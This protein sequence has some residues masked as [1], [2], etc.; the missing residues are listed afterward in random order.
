MAKILITNPPW[1]ITT[2]QGR[3]RLGIRAGSRWPLTTTDHYKPT[4][5]TPYPGFMGYATGYLQSQGIEAIFYDAIA[6]RHDYD[7]FYKRVDELK[8]DIII[9][10]TSTPSF[11]I[12]TQVTKR[13]HE[14]Y[15][16]CLVG[17][18]ASSFAEELIEQ[19]FIDYIL[20]GEYE[21]SSLEMLRTRRKG[22]Y[23]PKRVESLDDIPYPYRD[24][25]I[26]HHY[27]ECSCIKD[28]AFPQLW[29]YGSRGCAFHCS[30]CLW[31]HT[32]YQNKLSS[33]SPDNII[34]EADDMVR[35]Y[36][37]K[38]ILFD[39]DCW[40]LGGKARIMEIAD[41]L[42]EVGIPW[43][44][45]GRLDTCDKDIFKYVVDRGCVGLRLG[46][47]SLSQTL[48]DKTGKKLEVV[49]T[50]DMIEYIKT[51]DVSL[52]LLFMHHLPGETWWDRLKQDVR[53]R[54]L[55][56]GNPYIR[57]QNPPCV[58]FPGTPYYDEFVKAG[59]DP[60]K[61]TDWSEYDGANIG[62]NVIRLIKKY[63]QR[64]LK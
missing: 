54:R 22:V 46:V 9:Q 14:K 25:T 32:M 64:P 27:R 7:T 13:L 12:D 37:C 23:E 42:N 20:K 33:R 1:I 10:E 60:T 59:L 4:T 2:P 39:D 43:S 55:T 16:T 11:D 41:G 63:S 45:I 17:P 44:I 62:Q 31:V 5:Y 21:Y 28:L 61:E 6:S 49:K 18:H 50:L 40:N 19:P 34:A 47:E 38:Y 15:E 56:W 51:L 3:K 48:L 52:Y 30:F 29:I 26:I 53:I 57:F 8:P 35:K 58:P 36:D 24:E